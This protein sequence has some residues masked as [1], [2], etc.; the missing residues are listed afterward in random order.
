[1]GPD[2]KAAS[3]HY[4]PATGKTSR[5]QRKNELVSMECGFLRTLGACQKEME[6]TTF[7]NV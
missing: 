4:K 6:G 3:E 7:F 1:M 2:W 5:L